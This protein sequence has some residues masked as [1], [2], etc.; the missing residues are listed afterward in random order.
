LISGLLD[1]PNIGYVR[2]FTNATVIPSDKLCGVMG[3]HRFMLYISNYEKSLTGKM[4][5]NT[6]K[7]K[8]KLQKNNIDYISNQNSEWLDFAADFDLQKGR[9]QLKLAFKNCFINM[10]HRL[11]KGK[12]YRCPHQYAGVQLGKLKEFPA[13][14][15]DI[16]S[17]NE[18]ELAQALEIFAGL[19]FTDACRYCTL[20]F[21]ALPVPAGEQLAN[22]NTEEE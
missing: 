8:E 17:M 20:P 16:H 12:L 11:Y 18:K 21:D 6:F 13:E 5:E 1:I 10:C 2:S 15:L 3:N 4:L 22:Q 14:C 9:E 19:E 7:T